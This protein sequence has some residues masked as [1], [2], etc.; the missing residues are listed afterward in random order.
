MVRIK[1]AIP[2]ENYCLKVK[3]STNEEGIFDLKLNG[4]LEGAI[5]SRLKDKSLFSHVMIDEIAGTI[6]WPN[7]IDLCP[8]V[9]YKETQFMPQ[10]V[11]DWVANQS[12]LQLVR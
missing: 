8:D 4:W 11:G 1:R 7:G 9:V 10:Q 3:F 12:E 6:C 5:F 2:L